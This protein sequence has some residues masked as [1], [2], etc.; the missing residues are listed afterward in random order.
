MIKKAI[1]WILLGG[2]IL[3]LLAG[4]VNRTLAKSGEHSLVEA[5]RGEGRGQAQNEVLPLQG[6]QGN[7]LGGNQGRNAE[8][9]GS[10]IA[11][12]VELE[13][14]SLESVVSAVDLEALVVTYGDQE[15][16]EVSGRP[17]MFAQEQGFLPRTGDQLHLV[18]FFE[19]EDHLE[20]SRIDNL[21]TGETIILRDESS[22][23]MWAGWR[24]R[25]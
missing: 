19:T 2:L 14:F 24:R 18:G 8:P 3:V 7:G 4:A 6:G 11:Q 20:V 5:S 15:V 23:P 10:G 25:G 16:M 13:W 1:G 17:W 21:T 22:R 9:A 12:A